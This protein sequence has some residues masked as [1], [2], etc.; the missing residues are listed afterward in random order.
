MAK[1]KEEFEFALQEQK[2]IADKQL[3]D[4]KKVCDCLSLLLEVGALNAVAG[5]RGGC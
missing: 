3:A 1:L 4:Q 5:N 2:G